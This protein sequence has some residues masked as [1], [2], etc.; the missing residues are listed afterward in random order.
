MHTCPCSYLLCSPLLDP[1]IVGTIWPL[2][3]CKIFHFF[4]F[5]HFNW[6]GRGTVTMNWS[7]QTPPL[8]SVVSPVPIKVKHSKSRRRKQTPVEKIVNGH[9]L[10]Y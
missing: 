7:L 9:F 3:V 8:T 6:H 10:F 1:Q 5:W 4:I 2:E